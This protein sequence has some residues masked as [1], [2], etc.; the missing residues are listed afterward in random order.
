MAGGLVGG[1]FPPLKNDGGECPLLAQTYDSSPGSVFGG[2]HSYPGG[3]PVHVAVNLSSALALA[4]TYRR[5][6][7]HS[8]AAGLP[9]IVAAGTPTPA[10][11][12]IAIDQDIIIA[13][14]LW[15]DWAKTMV[16]Q[17]N[18]DGGEFAELN[19]GGAGKT[20]KYGA[21][22]E[23]RTGLHH[24]LGIARGMKRGPSQEIVGAQA[25]APS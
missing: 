10:Q 6:Y 20:D 12:D 16:F 23:S 2:H 15:H 11:S 25:S 21:A 4:D 18:A 14:P 17:G 3:L 19:F 22:G 7:G 24:I 9:E 8:N 1:V 13:A 5:I